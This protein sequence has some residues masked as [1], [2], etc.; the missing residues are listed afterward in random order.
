M[1]EMESDHIRRVLRRTGGK[2]KGPGGA[3]ELLDLKP[4]TLYSRMRKYQIAVVRS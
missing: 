3:A 1:A 2:I 4:S